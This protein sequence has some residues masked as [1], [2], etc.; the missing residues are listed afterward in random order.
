VD[1]PQPDLGD[2]VVEGRANHGYADYVLSHKATGAK[3]G[4]INTQYCALVVDGVEYLG[5]DREEMSPL[6]NQIFDGDKNRFAL[7]LSGAGD[8]LAETA[9]VVHVVERLVDMDQ[10]DRNKHHYGW[11]MKCHSYCYG[12]CEAN[13]SSL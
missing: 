1:D 6:I 10:D 4:E 8:T 12:D 3:A 7:L 11:C 9:A 5:C 2:L 13:V